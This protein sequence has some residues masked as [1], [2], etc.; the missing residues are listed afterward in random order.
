MGDL[1]SISPFHQR[2]RRSM[3]PQRRAK[4]FLERGGICGRSDLG[5]KNWGCGRKLAAGE[6][7]TI[8]HDPAL[9]NGGEDIDEQCFVICGWCRPAKDADDHGKAAKARAVTTK[10]L[11]PTKYLK[12]KRGFRKPKGA[13]FDW[14]R[15]KYVRDGGEE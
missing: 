6:V 10:L 13:K 4:I 7:W 11:V 12:S 8:E 2:P 15:G 14:S 1:P 3:T 5:D 9:E